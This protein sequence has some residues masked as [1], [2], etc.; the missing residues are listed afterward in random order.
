MKVIQFSHANGFGASTYGYFFEQLQPYRINAVEHIGH[1]KHAI[2][3]SWQPLAQELIENILSNE[4]SKVIG[5][6][7]SLGG[8]ILLNAVQQQPEL[9]EQVFFLDPP[10]FAPIKRSLLQM[11]KILGFFDRVTPAGRTKVRRQYFDNK[12][13]ARDYFA[14]KR[15]FKYFHPQCVADYSN[16]GLKPHPE[17][18]WQLAFSRQIEYQIFQEL[19]FLTK[20]IALPVPSYFLF[21]EQYQVLWKSDIKWLRWLLPNTQFIGIDGGHLFPQEQPEKIGKLIKKLIEQ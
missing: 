20:K 21:S 4:H 6:G 7:H 5:V 12:S 2:S 1:G 17:Q 8:G 11:T 10:L 15:L 18:H 19:P 3:P 9:F 14:S 16:H 13:E